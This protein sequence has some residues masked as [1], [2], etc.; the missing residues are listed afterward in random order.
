MKLRK[1]FAAILV[2]AVLWACT[3]CSNGGNAVY[4][5]SVADLTNWGGI[6]PGDRFPGMVVSENTT[7]INKDHDKSISELLVK[8]GQDVEAG[9]ELFCYDM[10][11]LQLAL[12][13]QKLEKEQLVATI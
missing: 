2:L 7:E 3:G 1:C 8:E 4:V 9:Q 5:Q 6:A 11:Q 10:E 12:D 13:K